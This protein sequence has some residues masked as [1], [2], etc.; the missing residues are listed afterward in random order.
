MTLTVPDALSRLARL[1]PAPLYVVGGYVRNQ[2]MWGAP[3]STDIDVC[4]AMT[5]DEVA[6]TLAGTGAKVI[7]VNP[8]VGTV[9]LRYEGWDFEY[10]TFRR[11]SYPIGGVHTPDKVVFVGTV[12][13]DAMRRDFRVNALYLDVASGEVLDPTGGIADIRNGVI[14]TTRTPREVFAEDGLR[15]LR[16]VRFCAELGFE[17]QAE[18]LLVAK[19]MRRQLEDISPERKREELDKIL[20]SDQKYGVADGPQRGVELL[21]ELELWPFLCL[22]GVRAI[23]PIF[24]SSRL[25]TR[26]AAVCYAAA[27]AFAFALAGL[28]LGKDGLR[29]ANKQVEAVKR[30]LAGM[31]FPLPQD[32]RYLWAAAYG[33]VIEEIGALWIDQDKMV[34]ARRAKEAIDNAKVPKSH[35]DLPITPNELEEMGVPKPMLGKV[36]RGMVDWCIMHLTHPDHDTCV[37]L[38]KLP[39]E[40]I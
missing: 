7:P 6:A 1:L 29:Y 28:A 25:E 24:A 13:E 2:L 39:K 16:M 27:G 38:A 37:R 8:R 35:K 12:E 5:V 9:L 26:L 21:N 10:T 40:E 20:L 3:R 19:E 22:S 4:G 31:D 11:D 34:A 30:L 14:S 15:I 18:A 36:M 17:P 23:N 33:D 32:E